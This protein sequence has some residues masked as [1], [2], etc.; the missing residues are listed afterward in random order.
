MRGWT[1]GDRAR[2]A[3]AASAVRGLSALLV[4]AL[5]ACGS[6]S[7]PKLL[8]YGDSCVAGDSAQVCGDLCIALD[9]QTGFCSFPCTGDTQ[10][11]E[12][13]FCLPAGRYG[14]V[15]QPLRGCKADVDCPA[16][17]SCNADT[18]NCFVSVTRGLC[19]PCQDDKQCPTGG[20]CFVG[21]GSRERFCTTACA[22]GDVC[23]TGFTCR[24]VPAGKAGAELKQCVPLNETCNAGRT[25]CAACSG[26]QE[27]GGP[28][29]LCVRN[30][31][32]QESFCGK[33][34]NPERNLCPSASC[35]PTKLA[36]AQNPDCPAGFACAIV[37]QSNDA[38]QRS[39]HQCVPIANT[40]KGYC[41]ASDD[42]GQISQCGLG[43]VCRQNACEPATD[44]RVCSPCSNNDDCR[45]GGFPEN[46]CIVNNCTDCAFRG[47]SFCSTSCADDAACERSFGAGFVCKEVADQGGAR[48][49]FCMPQRGTCQ[50][51][52][53]RL[54]ED[55]AQ[56]GA[57]D[58]VTGLCVSAGLSSFCSIACQRDAQCGDARYRCCEVVNGQYD[59]SEPQR[60]TSGPKSGQG[61][62]AP[63]TGLFGDDCSP[64][65]PPCQSGTCLD[66]GT[67]RVCSVLCSGGAACPANFVCRKATQGPGAAAQQVDVCFPSG[68][69]V[70]GSDCSF[71]PAACQSGLCIRKELG[72]VCTVP[73]AGGADCP[74]GWACDSLPS[75]T[76]QTVQACLPPELQP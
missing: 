34:C 61:V 25:L 66:L 26:D 58:C 20:S 57:R 52:L 4:V 2:G 18:G 68:G 64:G 38:A 63:I 62:C 7:Q 44:G 40:C 5:A 12:G 65:Q 29:D 3:S 39:L 24:S 19:S 51:G 31:V 41:D 72:P 23:P 1:P 49:K 56:N 73:C 42:V 36:A 28:F 75:V 37:G 60:G 69:G 54:G 9:D 48:R 27:C 15:C 43:Q 11:P 55:C 46:R 45:R 10:C 70:A 50:S 6:T 71:G 59:C 53:R 16:G 35:D 76:N 33:D 22:S 8:N 14:T 67:A 47:E 32:S 17:H 74:E 30:V 21:V 13:S